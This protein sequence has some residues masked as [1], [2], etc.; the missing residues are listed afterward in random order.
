[1]FAAGRRLHRVM[2]Q[3]HQR[4]HQ[5]SPETALAVLRRIQHQIITINDSAPITGVTT[6]RPEQTAVLAAL[7]LRKPSPDLQMQCQLLSSRQ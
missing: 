3:R 2:R 6:I 5:A 4:V 7:K 1:M